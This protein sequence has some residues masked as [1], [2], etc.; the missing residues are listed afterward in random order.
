[1]AVVGGEAFVG[2]PPHARL[3]EIW[4]QTV[5]SPRKQKLEHPG[6]LLGSALGV[7]LVTF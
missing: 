7:S 2:I 4:I 6:S 3:S 1:M 5:P